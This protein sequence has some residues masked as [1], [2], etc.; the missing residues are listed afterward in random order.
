MSSRPLA[1]A[2]RGAERAAPATGYFASVTLGIGSI[3]PEAV[4]AAPTAGVRGFW[5]SGTHWIAHSGSVAEIQARAA[6]GRGAAPAFDPFGFV[7][8]EAARLYGEPWIFDLDGDP[9]RPRLHGGFA[10][11]HGGADARPDD[12]GFWEPFPAVRFN[13]PAFEIEADRTGARLTVTGAFAP[14]MPGDRA[15]DELRRRAHRTRESLVR[16]EREGAAPGPVPPATSVEEP[17]GIGAWREAIERVLAAIANGT[18]RKV[19]LARP[20]DVTLAEVPDSASVLAAL[21]ASNP[22]AHTFLLEFARG[23]FFLGAAPELIGSLRGGT[24]H[25][26]AVAGSVPRG[27]D[28]EADEW[29][30]RQLL[31]SRKNRV[32]HEIVVEDIV[33]RLTDLGTDI[34][35]VREPALLRLPRIQHLRTRLEAEV[36]RGTHLLDLVRALHPTAAVCGYPRRAAKEILAGE[37]LLGRGWYAAPVGWLDETGAGEFAPALRSA[38]GRGPLLRLYAGAGIVEGSRP[39]SE[40]DE[41]RVKFQTMLQALGVARVP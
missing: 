34:S 24:F 31:S 5:Q 41:T 25:T 28:P 19:V 18:V 8:E 36:P 2:E 22:L 10:F 14:D 17:V 9:R 29:L 15:I 4:L 32:E 39:R 26:M 23:R 37:E 21:R 20:L 11:D 38:V 16:L 12:P 35:F 13:L 27:A 6:A 7:M 30:G 1:G 40:W 3:Q 33:E